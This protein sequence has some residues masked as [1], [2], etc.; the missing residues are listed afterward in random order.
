MKSNSNQAVLRTLASLG[1]GFD[2]VSEGELRRAMAAGADPAKCVFRR[3]RKDRNGNRGLPSRR[4]RVFDSTRGKRTGTRPHQPRLRR[5]GSGGLRR[6]SPCAVNPNVDAH[7]HAK[8]TTGTYE[9]KFGIAFEEI[10]GG[11]MRALPN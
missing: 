3:R 4:K 1:G 9:N 10:E 11:C 7:T 6:S 2:I 8:I 5:A